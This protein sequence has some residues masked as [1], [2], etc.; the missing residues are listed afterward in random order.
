MWLAPAFA[1]RRYFACMS[2]GPLV[3]CDWLSKHLGDSSLCIV[4]CRFS[5]SEASYGLN[6]FQTAHIPRA[7]FMD[8][9]SELSG[10]VQDPSQGGR[11]PLPGA[12]SFERAC[13]ARGISSDSQVVSYDEAGEGGAARLWWLLR[14]FGHPAVAVLDGGLNAWVEEGNELTAEQNAV[15]PG[16]FRARPRTDDTADAGE[17]ALEDTHT[18]SCLL[19]AR[20]PQRFAG[21]CE[22]I[23]PAAGHIPGASNVSYFDLA[24]E[25]RFLD[26]ARLRKALANA[27]ATSDKEIIAYCGSGVTACTVM[28]AAEIAGFD[29]RLYPGSFSEWSRRGLP[30]S[31]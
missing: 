2:F 23:D 1:S 15:L 5:L 4:D 28:L 17:L 24:P 12:D 19:D 30:V 13:R 31:R 21:D 25:G 11:H 3:S 18:R 9:G 6:A 14:H 22:P 8:L 10:P 26:I 7:T 29:A 20:A 27:G 16:N